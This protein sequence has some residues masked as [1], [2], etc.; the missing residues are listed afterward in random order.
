MLCVVERAY[1]PRWWSSGHQPRHCDVLS[2]TGNSL[3]VYPAGK[4][5]IHQQHRC[6][7]M[8]SSSGVAVPLLQN[9]LPPISVADCLRLQAAMLGWKLIAAVH[10]LLPAAA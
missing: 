6:A 2:S 1:G 10:L 3:A 8:S 7:D 9:G 5:I 4:R